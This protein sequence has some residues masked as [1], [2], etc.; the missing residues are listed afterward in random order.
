MDKDEA[1]LR[2]IEVK[3]SNLRSQYNA[4][5]AGRTKSAIQLEAKVLT[6]LKEKIERRLGKA[7]L[8]IES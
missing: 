6:H 4:P 5:P 2:D 8:P 3:L 1:M 7:R